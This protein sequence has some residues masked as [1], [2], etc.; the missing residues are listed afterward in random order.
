MDQTFNTLFITLPGNEA[1]STL[2]KVCR[3][4]RI[5]FLK[6]IKWL[7]DFSLM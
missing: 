3:E 1:R 4:L 6:I 7:E 5:Q 2:I